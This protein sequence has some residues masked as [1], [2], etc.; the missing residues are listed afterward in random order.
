MVAQVILYLH[1]I[2]PILQLCCLHFSTEQ[3]SF[4]SI[5]VLDTATHLDRFKMKSL[6]IMTAALV[7]LVVAAPTPKN[8]II[9]YMERRQ[10]PAAP[11][12]DRKCG[13]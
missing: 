2:L 11:L 7:S 10:A 9:D 13:K 12:T 1:F 6:Q 8:I 5:S 4:L 3:G